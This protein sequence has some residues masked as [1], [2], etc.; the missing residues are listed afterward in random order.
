MVGQFC[1]FISCSGCFLA[2]W[3]HILELR[4]AMSQI[5]RCRRRR[6]LWQS[7]G[8]TVAVVVHRQMSVPNALLLKYCTCVERRPNRVHGSGAN[9]RRKYTEF[10]PILISLCKGPAEQQSFIDI[11]QETNTE[12]KKPQRKW[13][14]LL[15][16]TEHFRF[17]ADQKLR[18]IGTDSSSKRGKTETD[19]RHYIISY[20]F[21]QSSTWENRIEQK[22]N[23]RRALRRWGYEGEVGS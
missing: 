9:L 8:F 20:S 3:L 17:A 11:E 10:Q 12:E 4:N 2:S 7:D 21:D 15:S 19:S 1:L 18:R 22:E 13:A 14:L 23:E 6:S 16:S 5:R